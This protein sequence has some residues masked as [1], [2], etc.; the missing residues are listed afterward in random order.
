MINPSKHIYTAEEL[1]SIG[2]Q[3]SSILKQYH[4]HQHLKKHLIDLGIYYPHEKVA[5]KRERCRRRRRTNKT[6]LPIVTT[7]NLRSMNNNKQE[8]LL[9]FLIDSRTDIACL[10]ETWINED[11]Q[12]PIINEILEL[13]HVINR[14]RTGKTA[15]GTLIAISKEYASTFE[16]IVATNTQ[17]D[18]SNSLEVTTVRIN[19]KRLIRGYSTCVV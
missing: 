11:N 12:H 6:N 5:K 4:P 16:E 13:F 7:T 3:S 18:G 8:E 17:Q 2:Q 1:K 14:P 9:Q 19:P 10:T 15:G